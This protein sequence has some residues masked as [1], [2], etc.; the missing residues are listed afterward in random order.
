MTQLLPEK[1]KRPDTWFDR[2]RKWLIT[3]VVTWVLSAVIAG[4]FVII[5][6]FNYEFTC[7]SSNQSVEHHYLMQM[8]GMVLESLQLIF[9]VAVLGSSWFVIN[10]LQFERISR[11]LLLTV[12][13][14]LAT[15]IGALQFAM[16]LA[17]MSYGH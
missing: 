3:A 15:L 11:A 2:N 13:V 14:S 9:S 8:S 17:D 10:R 16:F 5:L 4:A 7:C 6:I 12:P 1:T